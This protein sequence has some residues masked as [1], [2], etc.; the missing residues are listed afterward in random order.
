MYKYIKLVGSIDF[1]LYSRKFQSMWIENKPTTVR[2]F[3][4]VLNRYC[5]QRRS[6]QHKMYTLP[7]YICIYQCCDF[8]WF[9]LR[10]FM[11]IPMP[12]KCGGAAPYSNSGAKKC[13]YPFYAHNVFKSN[14]VLFIN[15]S[16][17]IVCFGFK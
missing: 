5:V 2:L 13:V 4:H 16:I 9:L 14:H 1:E 17:A 7:T 6:I 3:K 10:V 12:I 8:E 11:S 15:Q